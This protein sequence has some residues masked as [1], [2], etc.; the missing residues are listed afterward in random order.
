MR[1]PSALAANI[2]HCTILARYGC[3]STKVTYAERGKRSGRCR[4]VGLG[5]GAETGARR[6]GGADGVRAGVGASGRGRGAPAARCR[7]G[8]L[9]QKAAR[10]PCTARGAQAGDA[11][12]AGL[13]PTHP[14]LRGPRRDQALAGALHRPR[15]DGQ[16][17]GR[18]ARIVHAGS[19]GGEVTQGVVVRFG[20]RGRQGA[21]RGQGGQDG[22]GAPLVE[23]VLGR[24]DPGAGGRRARA[25]DGGGDVPEV[26]VGADDVHDLDHCGARRAARSTGP[27]RPARP[28]CAAPPRLDA[29]PPPEVLGPRAIAGVPPGQVGAPALGG[30]PAAPAPRA[31]GSPPPSRARPRCGA[32]APHRRPPPASWCPP[33]P[34]A[35]LRP[36]LRPLP[37]P[38]DGRLGLR[39]GHRPPPLGRPSR[40]LRIPRYAQRFGPGVYRLRE[41]RRDR[42][43][44]HHARPPRR[45]SPRPNSA[46][47]GTALCPHAPQQ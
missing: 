37:R 8:W 40:H 4:A 14:G 18:E 34:P 15:A 7:R 43:P 23:A 44:R 27:R 1:R 38:R 46:S 41:G 32:R 36:A 26:A 9:C 39:L 42:R 24:L 22:G 3:A 2:A 33:P 6:D 5:R 21:Q 17:A 31:P 35:P 16:R 20:G 30:R 25:P 19:V 10:A 29:H 28:R 12:D 11:L 45:A 13:G 47:S